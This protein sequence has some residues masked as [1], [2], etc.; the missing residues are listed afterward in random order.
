MS[1]GEVV[2]MLV[3]SVVDIRK[4][5]TK[6][7]KPHTVYTILVRSTFDASPLYSLCPHAT[8]VSSFSLG[9]QANILHIVSATLVRP[10]FDASQS[11]SL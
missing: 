5:A 3:G 10:I 2:G 11:K 8:A 9:T 1:D 6:T 4:C 7:C